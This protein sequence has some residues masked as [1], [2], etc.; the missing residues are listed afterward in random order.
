M[1]TNNAT[2]NYVPSTVAFQVYQSSY[3]WH[4]IGTSS[5]GSYAAQ[6]STY[7]NIIAYD[8]TSFDTHSAYNNTTG[9]FTAPQSGI[10]HFDAVIRTPGTVGGY[11]GGSNYIQINNYPGQ[12]LYAIEYIEPGTAHYYL[13]IS[14]SCTTYLSKGQTAAVLYILSADSYGYNYGATYF[15]GFLVQ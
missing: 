5:Y 8:S 6:Y 15:T 10:Y 3:L 7:S 2:N 14:C 1:A 12:S 4:L 9:L 13:N 11:I